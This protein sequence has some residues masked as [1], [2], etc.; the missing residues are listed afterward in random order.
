M[1]FQSYN[2]IVPVHKRWRNEE[3]TDEDITQMTVFNDS[4]QGSA[5]QGKV[6]TELYPI[7]PPPKKN[8][9]G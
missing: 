9:M 1:T 7:P 6:D 8:S 2:I 3:H 5:G 4:K